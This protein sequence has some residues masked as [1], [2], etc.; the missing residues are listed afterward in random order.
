MGAGKV[1][2]KLDSKQTIR[3]AIL[4][5]GANVLSL[6]VGMVM[7]PI[8]T[9]V[10][11]T[12]EMG[13]V[14]TFLSTRNTFVILATLASYSYVHKAMLEFHEEKKNYMGSIALFCFLVI[15]I[16]YAICL[17]FR[18]QLMELF[19]LDDFLYNWL[20]ISSLAFALYSLGDYYC[21]FHNKSVVVFL[22]VLLAGPVAQLLSLDFS[23]LLPGKRYIGRVLGLDFAYCLVAVC[24]IVW[25]LFSK[26][27]KLQW[28]YV[29]HTLSFTVPIIPH[30]LSQM[31]LTQ[32]DL[33]MISYF[34]G[35]DKS[36]I[37]GM[38]HTIGFL[39][40][41]V[42]S[43]IMAAWSPW[44]YRRLEE[45]DY[46]S[47]H[48]NGKII[49]LLGTYL[50]IGLL[51]VATELIRIF[52]TD[53]YLPCIYIVPLLVLAMYFQFIYLFFYDLEYYH[54]KSKWI[55]TAS[56]IA[57]IMNAG[58]NILLIP[59]IG[60]MAACYTTV[61]SYLVLLLLNYLFCRKLD[62]EKIY[63]LKIAFGL[64]VAVILYMLFVFATIDYILL[65]YLLLVVITILLLKLEWKDIKTLL[66]TMKG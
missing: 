12:T 64:I 62:V 41:T 53:D 3:T 29:K 14:S 4:N 48:D 30:L 52:L 25:L 60:Y 15:A 2:K 63:N 40:F 1:D 38:G 61:A 33:I 34:A 65:R 13:V 31:I 27:I 5:T 59:R 6:I 32:C 56:V 28:K 23:L 21:I 19:S 26:K 7:I 45:H 8:I 46:K 54:K 42:M 18:S 66:K 49:M 22:I 37:Y 43:Q 35:E 16:S 20:F 47:I 11:S 17:P 39:A 9:R 36:G 44:V 50:T 51:T 10:L 55:A 24:V 58:L 57:A